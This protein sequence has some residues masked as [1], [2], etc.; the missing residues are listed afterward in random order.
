[1]MIKNNIQLIT[2]SILMMTWFSFLIGCANIV[3]PTGGPQDL[4]PPKV[5]DSLS[6]PNSQYNT[7][8]SGHNITLCFD[9]TTEVIGLKSQTTS[10]P[11]IDPKLIKYKTKPIKFKDLEG[12]SIKGT[13]VLIDL[14]QEL[15]SNTTYVINFG[16]AFKDINEGKIATNISVAF[17]TG[18]KIDSMQVSGQVL[19]NYT[20]NPIADVFVGLY[21]LTDTV[22]PITS[23]PKYYTSTDETG[24]FILNYIKN[25]R[26][27]IY[28]FT[29]LNRNKKYDNQTEKIAFA[30]HNLDL[31]TNSIDT[32]VLKLFQENL[33]IPKILRTIPY[34]NFQEI[35]FNK[36]MQSVTIAKYPN[37]YNNL[38]KE[39][40]LIRIYKNLAS[41]ESIKLNLTDSLGQ[42]CD[43]TIPL[44]YD[45]LKIPEEKSNYLFDYQFI[46]NKI[47]T[48]IGFIHPIFDT[49]LDSSTIYAKEKA[50]KL[51]SISKISWN[52]NNTQLKIVSTLPFLTDTAKMSIF[53]GLVNFNADT[54]LLQQ[55]LYKVETG[56]LGSLFFEVNSSVEDYIIYVI[57]KQNEI[58][59]TFKSPKSFELHNMSPQELSIKVLID[60]NS[61]GYFDHGNFKLRQQPEEYINISEKFNVKAGWEITD[62]IINIKPQR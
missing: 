50:L 29:D 13:R 49:I 21:E 61:N 26:Y 28:A 40:R 51:D 1:M 62:L 56:Q 57:N 22:N 46:N 36:G 23:T 31:T 27:A 11:E 24:N 7:N 6:Y 4:I 30:D 43:T 2:K 53:K 38:L 35:Y 18:S 20:T 16:S 15:D 14:N 55:D 48:N 44:T 58:I 39:N 8:R 9:E 37:L 10:N 52:K 47:T 42:I 41:S 12:K 19:D 17:S 32:L 33:K 5:I 59:K 3:A 34:K 45:S 54:I 60:E 25:G